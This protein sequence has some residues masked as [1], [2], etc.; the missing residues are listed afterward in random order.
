MHNVSGIPIIVAFIRT[1]LSCV[2]N[3]AEIVKLL[4]MAERMS[5][6]GDVKKNCYPPH[7]SRD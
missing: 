5:M 2:K 3:P 1:T 7:T 4:Q 6:R